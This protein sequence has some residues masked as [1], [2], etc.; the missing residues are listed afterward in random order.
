MWLNFVVM[1][2]VEFPVY[3]GQ[4]ST[5]EKIHTKMARFW[6]VCSGKIPV[7][8]DKLALIEGK[9][10]NL[11]FLVIPVVPTE[12]WLR[13]TH[14]QVT[15]LIILKTTSW[16]ECSYC[17]SKFPEVTGHSTR[18]L[19]RGQKMQSQ[20]SIRMSRET[21]FS[22]KRSNAEALSPVLENFRRRF[23]RPD[24]R[25]PGLRGC[26]SQGTECPPKTT[27][28]PNVRPSSRESRYVVSS[29]KQVHFFPKSDSSFGT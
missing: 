16:L 3:W 23:S 26:S 21:G 15:A 22:V 12:N 8:S 29:N 4:R 19:F 28:L 27:C 20:T 14:N 10:F 5:H 17:L 18:R 11:M 9:T 7:K 6:L 13:L 2:R 24:W 1:H 25:P